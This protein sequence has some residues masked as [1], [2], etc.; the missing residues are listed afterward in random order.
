[1]SAIANKLDSVKRQRIFVPVTTAESVMSINYICVVLSQLYSTVS[2]QSLSPK[3]LLLSGIIV[4]GLGSFLGWYALPQLIRY[5][6]ATVSYN[7]MRMSWLIF[8]YNYPS[9]NSGN[10]KCVGLRLFACWNCGF[11]SCRGHGS[12]VMF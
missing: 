1:M 11:E 4:I 6:I 3:R 5:Q 9:I 7:F 8:Q 12:R 2:F 10:Y